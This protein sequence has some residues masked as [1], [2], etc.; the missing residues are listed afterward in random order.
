M[1]CIKYCNGKLDASI[2]VQLH[3]IGLEQSEWDS[4]YEEL[5]EC[6]AQHGDCV[7]PGREEFKGLNQWM[8]TKHQNYKDPCKL[9]QEKII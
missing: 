8:M 5:R 6:K 3:E 1:S 4:G 7:I 9:S 2:V